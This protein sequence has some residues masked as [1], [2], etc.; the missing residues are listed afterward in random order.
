VSSP[1]TR[2]SQNLAARPELAISIFDSHQAPYSG[3]GVYV[4]AM[5]EAM[6]ESELD[7]G[8]E[9]YSG[10]SR[11][12][13]LPEWDRSRV[14]APAKPRLYRASTIERFVLAPDDTRTPV[15]LT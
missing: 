14:L 13:G 9:I 4:S 2:H 15:P 7:A 3:Q 10:V 5:G 1:Q 6:P 8:L 11:E 12:R